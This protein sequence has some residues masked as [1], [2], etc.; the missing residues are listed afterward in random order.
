MA[1]GAL[2]GC[3][4][5][6]N[7]AS[8]QIGCAPGDITTT[9]KSG[10]QASWTWQAECQGRHYFCSLTAGV[11]SCTEDREEVQAAVSRPALTDPAGLPP[12][13]DSQV[14]EAV[15]A[16]VDKFAPFWAA[17]SPGAKA[18]DE[19]PQQRDFVAVCRSM[20]ENVQRCMH[21]G[22]VAVHQKACE[23]VL[24]RLPPPLRTKVDALFLEAQVGER[25]FSW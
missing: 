3:I 9:E 6:A 18:L 14:C 16:H 12:R 19:L 13:E 8:G 4:S 24:L 17:R 11:T 2:C 25:Q 7:M 22:Y 20:P 5:L 1:S 23:A 21:A 15:F 10:D